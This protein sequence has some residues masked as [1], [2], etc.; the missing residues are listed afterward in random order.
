MRQRAEG[1]VRLGELD[2]GGA[3]AQ[4]RLLPVLQRLRNGMA[5]P[6]RQRGGPHRRSDDSGGLCN[7]HRHRRRRTGGGTLSAQQGSTGALLPEVEVDFQG[8]NA[9]LQR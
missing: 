3:H 7:S 9:I 1:R 2:G 8:T 6:R 4:P 5:D